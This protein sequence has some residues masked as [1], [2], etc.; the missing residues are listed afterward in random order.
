MKN[1]KSKVG[2]SILAGGLS[3]VGSASAIDIVIDGSYE[4]S[5][6]NIT[7]VVG[8]GGNDTAGLD[9]GW[10]HFSSYTYSAGY[11][12][13]G[14][15]GSGQVYLRP[16]NSGGGS[17]IVMQT[18]SL[19]RAI[20]TAQIDG[21]QGQYNVSAWFSTYLGQNDYSDLFLQFLDTSL[22]PIGTTTA[23]GGA[24][25]VAALPGGTGHRAWGKDS[26][27]GLVPPG[28]R[29][30]VITTS[31]H[32]LSGS[33]DGYVD[34]VSL[35]VTNG[36]TPVQLTLAPANNASNVI[37]AVVLTA[38]FQ[39]GSL[40]LNNA[41]VS[42]TFD[43]LPVVPTFSKAGLTTTVS[44]DPPGLLSSLSMHNYRVTYNNAGG[45]T[46]NTTN[47]ASFVV[48][49]WVNIT[50]PP[51]IAI[52]HFDSTAEGSLPVG[53]SQTNYTDI[54]DPNFD[55]GD[56]NSASY[57]TWVVVDQSRF[58]N[59][60]LSYGTHTPTT[61]YL[62]VLS[63][64]QFNVVNGQ[65]VTNLA[66]GHICFGDSGY[67]D[68]L[69][70][71]LYLFSPDIALGNLANIY[72]SYNS[73]WEQ[74]Q[75]SIAAVEYSVDSGTTWLPVVYMLD[76]PDVVRDATGA[77]DPVATF[78]TVRPDQATYVDP[79]DSQTKGGNYGAFIAVP[80]AQWS[81]LAPYISPRID[82][83]PVESKR[84]ELF[85]LP[86]ADGQAHV[87]LRFAHAGTDSWYFGIDEVGLYSIAT[88]TAP[89]ATT[90]TPSSQTAAIGNAAGFSV[91]AVGPGP[92][93]YQW[94]H[95]GTNLPGRTSDQLIV[96][97][98][99]VTDAGTYDVVV[100][101]AGGSSASA[102]PAAV[103]TVINPPVFV[104][105]QW[106]FNNG[107][108]AAT[109]GNDLQ[110]HDAAV[111]ADTSFG[112][113]TALAVPDINGV[114]ASIVHIV[115]NAFP[116]GGFTMF[117]GAVPNGGGAFVNQYTLIYD[118]YLPFVAWRSL[119]Q[120]DLSNVSDGD[121]FISPTGG[122]GI[123]GTYDGNVAIGDWH[124]IALAMDLSGPGQAP[125]LA[126]FVDGVKVGNQTGGLSSV[127]GR[128][129]LGT[130]ALLF[131][132][133]DGDA[134][135]TYISSVQFSN[136]RR[137]DAFIEALGGPSAAKIPG[138]ISAR[139]QGS[140]IIIRWTG[141]VPLQSAD[142]LNGPW[143]TVTGA[144]SPYTVPSP[145]LTKYYRPQIP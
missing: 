48:G 40:P 59:S 58:T 12:Q 117:H 42:M 121:L 81:T 27:T 111:Q 51:P 118:V 88:E 108:L 65:V 45:A 83:N 133:N 2:L 104:T 142:S 61:D 41:S 138:A 99:H 29:Y 102:A 112:T 26:K 33:P 23:I 137:P 70:Q 80:S 44:Y 95:N 139:P 28:A 89:V 57:A 109:V 11:T 18:N 113:T 74:N 32:A 98:V 136:G 119:L 50:L 122:I 47:Q 52:E 86:A 63:T 15:S 114:P 87:R 143:T 123:S 3:F 21:S 141:G 6:N 73:L 68:G 19:T 127:D 97:N 140:S 84:V 43:N 131:A 64:N 105:G 129:S 56:L 115:P 103:L 4:S 78:S 144:T 125:V 62:R 75:D 110:F 16:Y 85:R 22:N 17:S 36:F 9:G 107:N 90:P 10:T 13:A 130:S 14:P 134:N 25:F 91:T 116:W 126:K 37:P 30:A 54:T 53:W 66:Q 101:N 1:R 35:D 124:R 46:P 106:D 72:L 31:A 7:G 55:L 67:R 49:P 128:F 76:R 5:T 8:V 71:V 135:D 100:S 77:I 69:S 20:T 96:T 24:A 93:S 34:L 92:I 39:D 60:F 79:V 145:G 38:T 120:T 94:R 82:D 132:D